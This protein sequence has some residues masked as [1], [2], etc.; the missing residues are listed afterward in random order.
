MLAITRERLGPAEARVTFVGADLFTWQPNRRFEAA[1]FCF[2]LSH[3]PSE[4]L[5]KFLAIVAGALRLGGRVFFAVSNRDGSSTASNHVLLPA[6]K[7][8]ITRRLNDGTPYRVVENFWSPKE[9]EE[10]CLAAASP[11]RSARPRC[12]FTY[13]IGD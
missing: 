10:R 4:R 5:D 11:C 2:W 8:V 12:Y 3:V 7:E 1:V 6:G 9:L 13:G